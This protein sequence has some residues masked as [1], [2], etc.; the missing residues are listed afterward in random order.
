MSRREQTG[1]N[2]YVMHACVGTYRQ[3]KFDKCMLD[4]TL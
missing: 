2:E 4:S 3:K 1:V